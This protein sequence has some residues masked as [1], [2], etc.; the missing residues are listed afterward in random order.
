MTA[1]ERLSRLSDDTV[2]VWAYRRGL[3]RVTEG[4]DFGDK[5]VEGRPEP[6]RWRWR[7]SNRWHEVQPIQEA[8]SK[9]GAFM[10]SRPDLG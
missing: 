1:A 4:L 9:V 6:V 7:T 10:R 8:A 3:F 2:E 5:W